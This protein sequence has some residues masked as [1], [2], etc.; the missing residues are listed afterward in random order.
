M[1]CRRVVQG[2]STISQQRRTC[3]SQ[4]AHHRA[5]GEGSFLGHLAETRLTK[6]ESLK[7]YL[8]APTWVGRVRR[9]RRGE[10]YFN[11]SQGRDLAEAAMLAACSG[12]DEIRTPH[13]PAGGARTRQRRAR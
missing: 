9:R 13:Q 3:F 2:G 8:D 4:R 1:R 5:Q 11:K 7:L 12:A 6:N 10:Y